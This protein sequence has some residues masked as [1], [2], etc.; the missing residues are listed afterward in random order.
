MHVLEILQSSYPSWEIQHS[1]HSRHFHALRAF[2]KKAEN[3]P[4]K[5]GT[6]S[7]NRGSAWVENS[8]FVCTLFL[9]QLFITG[10][11]SK[12]N[13]FPACHFPGGSWPPEVYF[14]A[15]ERTNTHT[16]IHIHRPLPLVAQIFRG[17]NLVFS[18]CCLHYGWQC[19]EPPG[20]CCW[21]Q[22]GVSWQTLG[23]V[24]FRISGRRLG[25]FATLGISMSSHSWWNSHTVARWRD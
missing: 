10:N 22:F 15:R 20:M 16:H 14:Q 6:G 4:P 23:S 9:N 11:L 2:P 7:Q 5:M 17:S 3:V 25:S 12:G 8:S 1:K 18:I 19:A 24:A 13:F 21:I